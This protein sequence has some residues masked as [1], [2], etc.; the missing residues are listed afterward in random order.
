ME[1]PSDTLNAE[2]S[3]KLITG[4]VV[5]RPIAWVSTVNQWGGINLA[6]F[7]AFTFV[8]SFP[9]MLGFNVG[10]RLGE[11]KDTARNIRAN[12]DYVVNIADESMLEALHLSSFEHPPEVSEAEFL[13]LET[14]SCSMV[15]GKRLAKAPIS[16]E[17]RLNQILN[18]GSSGADFIVG[19]VLLFHVRDDLLV[20][21]KI[22]SGRLRPIC[23]LAGPNYAK[24]GEI[25]TMQPVSR[26]PGGGG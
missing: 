20:N 21:G 19:E 24:L 7:S 5:P 4:T 8:C 9:V 2:E 23:R 17:C 18:F 26:L 11:I 15:R 1:I 14:V 6:P 12:S 3:Y 25:I 13:G 10:R 22:D 16:M